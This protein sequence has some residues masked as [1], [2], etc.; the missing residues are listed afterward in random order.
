MSK[1]RGH[2]LDSTPHRI[3][4]DT[5][6]FII[7]FLCTL[8]IW[9]FHSCSSGGDKAE[10]R[11]I[12]VTK[13]TLSPA[14]TALGTVK[15]QVGAEVRLG[16]RIPGK[17]ERLR[18]NVGDFVKKGQTIAELE[19]DE[20]K[21][22]VEKRKAE[23]D[24]AFIN[25]AATKV[26]GPIEVEKAEAEWGRLKAI[27][28]LEAAEY[29][30]QATLFEEK[31]TSQQILD[32]AREELLV[33]RKDLEASLKTLE[34]TKNR[35][36]E[37]LKR[38]KAEVESARAELKIAEVELSY[39]TLR[40]PISGIIASVST[41]EGETVAVGLSAPT[42]VTIIDLD[43]L[44]VETYVD[45][46]DIGKIKVGQKAIFA[47]EAFPSIDIEGEVVGIYPKAILKENVV[48]Y[49]VVVMSTKPSPVVLRPEMTANVSIFLESRKDVILIPAKCVKKS[50][51]ADFVY[52]LENGKPVRREVRI[53]WKQGQ[54]IEIREGLKEG[55][56]VL[57]YHS[58]W[59][60]EEL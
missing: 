57:E 35:F 1:S 23:L 7:V 52:V 45:E 43:R 34:L 38:L 54:F 59:E 53:G 8:G 56:D 12:R 29:E 5:L 32:Q 2:I 30:R 26:I 15:P 40:A 55:D 17:V 37:D 33:A 22:T 4:P 25:L 18:A 39:A 48:F 47:V 46:V 11:T 49:N 20:L 9:S 41:Q 42:F 6:I 31:L 24:K 51:G 36:N 3:V 13:R 44:Q 28:D 21:A 58:D 50:G 10:F 27:H 60:D 16:A 19:K 14:V